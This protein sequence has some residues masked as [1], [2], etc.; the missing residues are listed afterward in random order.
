MKKKLL[1]ILEHYY[2]HT[3]GV[4]VLFKTL[5]EGLVKQ[6]FDVTVI[7]SR[8]K[9]TK[10]KETI[11]G[12]NIERISVPPF[13]RRYF[14]TF[15]AIPK[16]IRFAKK[17]DLIQ[18][19]T[20]NAALPA[21]ISAIISKKPA[22]IT[23]HEIIGNDWKKFPGMSFISRKIH[24]LLE[25][26]II[27]LNFEKYVTVSNSTKKNLMK[28]NIDENKIQTIHNGIDYEL[29]N[30]EKNKTN[31]EKIRKKLNIKKED[32]TF[33]F[34]GRPGVSKGFEY[35][36]YS[37]SKIFKD[38]KNAKFFTIL[39]KRPEKRYKFFR[40]KLENH[41]FNN[42]IKIIEPKPYNELP[43]YLGAVDCIVVPSLT[44][45]FGYCVA[46]SC[47]MKRIVIASNTTSIPEVISGK[48]ILVEP[49]NSRQ[50]S[51]AVLNASKGNYINNNL[52]KFTWND[53]IKSY[54]EL[55]EKYL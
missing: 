5:C 32:F 44:E 55:F 25:K 46:E 34:Y 18:T 49:A 27:K 20:Y 14:F 24:K 50:I 26:I 31:I 1:F 7:T 4:E 2:P 12:V 37:L 21:K 13:M 6:N 8:L 36:F 11:N 10:K 48:Y 42:K 9:N 45:G 30:F 53:C 35:L 54:K 19:T 43:W 38:N 28:L 29:F 17:S 33:L 3:G 47:A 40:N 41:R 39:G 51:K 15:F 23:V 16:S 22:I 52:K